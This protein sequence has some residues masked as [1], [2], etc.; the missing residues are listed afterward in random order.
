MKEPKAEDGRTPNEN[1][2]SIISKLAKLEL[3]ET[4]LFELPKE[5]YVIKL[6]AQARRNGTKCTS[7]LWGKMFRYMQVT[8][9]MKVLVIRTK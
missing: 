5:V 4:A 3:E 1:T 7:P 8:D 6:I 2:T 9:L